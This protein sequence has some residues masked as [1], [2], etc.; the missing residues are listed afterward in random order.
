MTLLMSI[1][2]EGGHTAVEL[3]MSPFAIA[4]IA[5]AVFLVLGVVTWSYRDVD[6][7]HS[8]KFSKGGHDSH[9]AGH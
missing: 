7:R 3:P 2:A 5:L 6:N 4:G 9:S 1:L 8:H